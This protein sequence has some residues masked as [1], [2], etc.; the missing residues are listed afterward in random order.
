MSKEKVSI[1]VAAYNVEKYVLKCL[2]S[3]RTQTY[4]NIEIIV[5]DDGSID[6][7]GIL[8]DEFCKKEKRAK[9]FHQKNQGLSMARNNG[10]KKSDSELIVFVDGDDIVSGDFIQKLIDALDQK[11]DMSVCGFIEVPSNKNNSP[12]SET[13]TGKEATIKLLTELENYQIVSWNK[14]Y[15]KKLFKDIAFPEGEIHEDSLTTYKL[16]SKSRAVAFISDSLYYYIQRSTSIM[17]SE[18]LIDRL[19]S[20]MKAAREA[21]EYF[22]NEAELYAAAQISELLAYYSFLDNIFSGKIKEKPK[23]FIKYIKQ[24]KKEFTKNKFL[25]KKLRLYI[26]MTTLFGT[27]PYKIF[28]RIK[29]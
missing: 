21:K 3:L 26:Y 1:I 8:C 11:T 13:L 27:L 4:E 9:V 29:H 24:H 6:K 15:R 7:T 18:K 28:R 17:N 23:R 19:E 22:K 12:K 5:I 20:K 2:E 16:M 10:I 25:T 14:M